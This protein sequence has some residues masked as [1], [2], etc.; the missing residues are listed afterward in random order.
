MQ[1][2]YIEKEISDYRIND[3]DIRNIEKLK[4]I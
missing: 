1:K 3:N 4:L 2:V